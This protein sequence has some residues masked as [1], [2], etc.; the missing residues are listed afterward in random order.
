MAKTPQGALIAAT[1]YL[2]SNQP[3]AG[4]PRA[5]LHRSTIAGL[6]LIGAALT[7]GKKRNAEGAVATRR[8]DRSPPRGDRSPH[9]RGSP[10]QEPRTRGPRVGDAHNDIVQRKV[11]RARAEHSNRRSTDS[12]ED[13]EP[14]G[15]SCFSH[16]V[17]HTRIP[18][19][20]KLPSDTAKYDGLQEP[21]T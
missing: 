14:C 13:D 15:A 9:R 18:K 17:R 11:D 8:P 7:P 20:F 19:G 6:G 21:K 4:D 16:R 3:P 1:T 2:L 12:G 10:R 5:A